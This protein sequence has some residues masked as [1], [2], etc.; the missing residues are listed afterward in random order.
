MSKHVL[1]TPLS[2]GSKTAPSLLHLKATFK[3]LFIFHDTQGLVP[4]SLGKQ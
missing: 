1:A 4:V 2:A 3:W